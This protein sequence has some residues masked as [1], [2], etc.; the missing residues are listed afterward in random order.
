MC[1]TRLAEIYTGC[2]NDAKNRLLRTI[3][4]LCRPISSQLRHAS[5]IGKNWLN[6]NISSRCPHN[7]VNFGSL[8]AEISWRVCRTQQISMRFESWLRYRTDIAQRRW[9]KLCTMFDRLLSCYAMQIF[10]VSGALA[11]NRILR[12]ATF[13]LRPSLAFSYIGS[14]TVRHWSSGRQ[15]NFAAWYKEW[16]Y[17]TFDVR[18]F[19]QRALPILR[20][21]PSRWAGP[22]SSLWPPYVI[23][24]VIH[25]FILSFVLLLSSSVF[26]SSP[27]LSRRRLDVCHT[28]THG[29]ALVRI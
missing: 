21:R 6:S 28:S 8:A 3:G 19:Q 24:Q 5:T 14:V 27:N 9:T 23:G 26:F 13:T 20:G 1:C 12:G 15:P 10:S 17:G 16:N 22:H 2:K 25:I 11:P 7:M 18:H 29:V 4:Q